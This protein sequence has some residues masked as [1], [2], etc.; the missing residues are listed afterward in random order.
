[1]IQLAVRNAPKGHLLPHVATLLARADV[2]CHQIAGRDLGDT[3]LYIVPQSLLPAGYYEGAYHY[4]FTTPSLDI[5]LADH[6]KPYRGRGPCMLIND[7]GLVEDI[8]P[9]DLEYMVTKIVLHELAHILDRP[10]LFAD[11][12]GEDPNK[13]LFES[14]VIADTT[15]RNDPSD[16]PAF[17]GHGA[18][19]IRIALHLCHRATLLGIDIPPA[20]ICDGRRYGISHAS[21]YEDALGDEPARCVDMLFREINAMEAPPEFSQLWASDYVSYHVR[22]PHIKRRV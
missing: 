4:A 11:R 5:Y 20:G 9:F 16:L 14:L 2:L 12:T 8:G 7:L 13:L 19:F 3:P 15:K 22:F 10:A 17:Y 1:M 18:S 6:I 21:D